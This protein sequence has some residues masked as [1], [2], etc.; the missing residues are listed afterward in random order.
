MHWQTLLEKIEVLFMLRPCLQSVCHGVLS[1][2]A[3]TQTRSSFSRKQQGS[4][5]N[6]CMHGGVVA[7]KMLAHTAQAHHGKH[8]DGHAMRFVSL[9]TTIPLRNRVHK[10]RV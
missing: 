4:L 1:R 6:M 10:H 8:V 5:S 9:A 3:R 7:L 2:T